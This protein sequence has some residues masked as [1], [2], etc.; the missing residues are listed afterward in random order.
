MFPE[1]YGPQEVRDGVPRLAGAVCSLA[2]WYCACFILYLFAFFLLYPLLSPPLLKSCYCCTYVGTR[3][4]EGGRGVTK[5]TAPLAYRQL[6]TTSSRLDDISHGF[7]PLPLRPPP[8]L[9][10]LQRPRARPTITSASALFLPSLP[11]NASAPNVVCGTPTSTSPR[12]GAGARPRAGVLPLALISPS[13]ASTTTTITAAA[14]E[15]AA[16]FPPS[17]TLNRHQSRRKQE[18]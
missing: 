18:A 12:V 7:R 10:R 17:A 16:P 8:R 6:K 13:S 5:R 2:Y 1:P 11:T 14:A 4:R 9:L 3:K 15:A